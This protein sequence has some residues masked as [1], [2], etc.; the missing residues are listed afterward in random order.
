M[1]WIV[2]AVPMAAWLI[3]QRRVRMPRG[4]PLYAVFGCFVL[5]SVIQID[6]GERLA[7]WL[8]RTSWYLAAGVLWLYLANTEAKLSTRRIVSAVVW[9][10][11]ASVVGGWLGL[12]LP[13]GG[14]SSPVSLLLPE[15]FLGNELV[16]SMVIPGFAEIQD[17]FAGY[18]TRPKAPYFYTNGWGSA[19]ALLTPF[20]VGALSVPGIRPSRRVII[21]GLVASIVPIVLSLNRGLW[22]LLVL[23]VLY[24][25]VRRSPVSRT[26]GWRWPSSAWSSWR[27]S[28]WPRPWA[29]RSG[30]RSAPARAT[31]TSGGRSSTRRPSSARSSRRCSAGAGPGR[32]SAP[33]SPWA[34]T[35]RCGW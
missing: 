12:L 7:G 29:T 10:W 1:I 11:L 15:Q 16:Q 9:L 14:W 17:S 34:P 13:Y 2:L 32:A 30:V 35:A 26:G 19:M 21:I 33:S 18:F 5:A 22:M 28:W 31:A 4:F 3:A 25:I 6:S 24:T 8:V 27:P 20:A 23:G